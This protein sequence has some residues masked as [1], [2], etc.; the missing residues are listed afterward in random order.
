MASSWPRARRRAAAAMGSPS[1]SSRP[2]P[3]ASHSLG[4]QWGQAMGWAWKRRSD[5]SPYS[6]ITSYN[7]CYTKLLR[8][9]EKTAEK[10]GLNME[11]F[12]ADIVSPE[13]EAQ[14][15]KDTTDAR[16]NFV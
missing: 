9:V 15:A 14:L 10:I 16:N 8:T 4:P 6:R 7:V 2:S 1:D 12:H 11:K 13:V 5:G 3:A